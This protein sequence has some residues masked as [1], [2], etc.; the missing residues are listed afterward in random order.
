MTVAVAKFRYKQWLVNIS[1][2]AYGN[3][4]SVII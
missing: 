4:L 3:A 1:Q 2:A